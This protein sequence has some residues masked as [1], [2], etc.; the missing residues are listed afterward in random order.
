MSGDRIF[1]AS[2]DYDMHQTEE[3]TIQ[4]CDASICDSPNKILVDRKYFQRLTRE[5]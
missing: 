4:N 5:K 3:A 1:I 2:T